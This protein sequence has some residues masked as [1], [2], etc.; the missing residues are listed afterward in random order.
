[1]RG[2]GAALITPGT[3]SP[4]FHRGADAY[5]LCGVLHDWD[6]RRAIRILR[7]CRRAQGTETPSPDPN[8]LPLPTKTASDP[9]YPGAHRAISFAGA[10]V[11]KSDLG[12]RFTFDVTSESLK[13]V[14]RH[15]TSFSAAAQ[16]AGLSRIYASTSGPTTSLANASARTWQTRSWT[17]FCSQATDD[18]ASEQMCSGREF[19]S[20]LKHNDA[21]A[22]LA[23]ALR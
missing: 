9:S 4:R 14:K 13:G 22:L 1:M 20:K 19:T 21:G 11:L 6:D 8:W 5:L 2:A 18:L 23:S 16:E 17:R 15:F 7:N 10:Q 3:S 12:G